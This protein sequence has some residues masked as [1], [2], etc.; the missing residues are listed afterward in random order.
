MLALE[1]MEVLGVWIMCTLEC[2]CVFMGW[3]PK[4]QVRNPR[5]LSTS[6]VKVG[7]LS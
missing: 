7:S 2:T 3:R 5:S 4:V 6:F 1:D